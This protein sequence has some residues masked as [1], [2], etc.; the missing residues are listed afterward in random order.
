MKFRSGVG[1]MSENYLFRY[2]YKGAFLMRN[3]KDE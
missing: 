2:I 3:A 1:V